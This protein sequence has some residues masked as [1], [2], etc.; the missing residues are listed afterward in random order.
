MSPSEAVFAIICCQNGADPAVKAE[1]ARDG[2]RLA[3]S[4]RG[5][6]SFKKDS[7][8]NKAVGRYDHQRLPRGVFVRTASWSLGLAKGED[9]AANAK[10]AFAIIEQSGVKLPFD[11]VHIWPRDRVPVG[12]FDFEPGI[13]EVAM[14]VG[15][16]LAPSLK[17]RG[18]ITD[19]RFNR[20]AKRGDRILD[21]VLIEPSQ[22]AIGWHPVPKLTGNHANSTL[23][24][25]WPGGVQPIKSPGEVISRAYFKAAEAI[26]WSG[27]E[28]RTGDMAIEVGASPGG[29]CS[30]LLEM[31]LNVIGIDPAEMD[32]EVLE[33]Q[34]FRHIR[35]LAGEVPRTEYEGAKWLLVDSNVRPD[36]TLATV[37]QIVTHR[38]STIEGMILTLKVGGI[39]HA[40]RIDGWVRKVR[41]WGATDVAV[42]QLARSKIE[43]CLVAR[44]RGR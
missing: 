23:P 34:N 28:M 16:M 5:F 20:V 21:I 25:M 19:E 1:V 33:H 15:E 7:P 42:R 41:S 27:F 10:Q 32:E 43:V 26:A 3:Y 37:E 31:G 14:V 11:G 40:D 2:W 17:Q 36:Q 9:A 8:G 39:A 44:M 6:L 30:L 24:T 12:K 18:I 35:A 29:A 4:R 38:D 13:D 22:W